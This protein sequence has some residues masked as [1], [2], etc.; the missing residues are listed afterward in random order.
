MAGQPLGYYSSWPLFALSHHL[1]VCR[2][3]VIFTQYAVLGDDVVIA[4]ERVAGLYET[5]LKRL[6]VMISYQKS[7]ISRTGSAEFAKRFR[8]RQLTKDF[9]PVS[10]RNLFHSHHPFRLD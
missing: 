7:L 5:G 8:V 6:G 2:T 1:L 4:D 3:G 9:S 10:I